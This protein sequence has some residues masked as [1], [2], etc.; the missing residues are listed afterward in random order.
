MAA[1]VSPERKLRPC[2]L[3]PAAPTVELALRAHL[4]RRYASRKN[5]LNAIFFVPRTG[6]RER[7]YRDLLAGGGDFDLAA[8]LGELHPDSASVKARPNPATGRREPGTT[9][10]PPASRASSGS[11]RASPTCSEC[12]Q[13]LVRPTDLSGVD[14]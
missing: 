11:R 1:G 5:V 3:P 9:R 6:V 7:L 8:E 10:P 14:E 12:P 4:P 13:R 2:L